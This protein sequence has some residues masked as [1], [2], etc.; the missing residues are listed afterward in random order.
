VPTHPLDQLDSLKNQFSADNAVKLLALLK[1]VAGLKLEDIGS[2]TKLH[3]LLLFICAHPHNSAV[4]RQAEAL[5]KNFPNLIL[6]SE[7]DGNDLSSLEH[8]EN[9]GIAGMTVTDAFTFPIVSWLSERNSSRLTFYWDWFEDENRIGELWPMFMPLLEEDA[10]VEANIPFR[11]WLSQA[12]GKQGEVSWLIERF[13]QLDVSEQEKA[14]RYN[15]QKLYVQWRYGY[16]D[17][18][19]GLRGPVSKLFF[20]DGALISRR[21]VRLREEFSKPPLELKTLSVLEGQNAI[22]R[23]RAASTVRYRELYGFTNGDPKSVKQVNIGRGVVLDIISLPPGKRLP[24]RTYHAAMIYK[25]GV[26]IGYFEGL[27]LFERMESGFNLYYTFREGETAWLYA[28]LLRVMRQI[29]GVTTFSLDPYQIGF[30]NEEGIQSGAFWFY[31]KLGFRSTDQDI[32]KR[33]ESEEAKIATRD[34]YRTSKAML[35][36]LSTA[37]MILELEEN[38][39]GEWDSFQIRNMGFAIQRL[40]EK[41]F[42]G[43]AGR[44]R[45]TA[46]SNLSHDL[47]FQ[48]EVD[49][50][51]AFENMAVTLL[52]VP[53]IQTW[54]I[55]EQE[56]LRKIVV[57]K[58]SASE[59]T[60][61]RLL[62]KHGRLRKAL[63]Q[64][65]STQHLI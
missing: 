2:L 31:R 39:T 25:N 6:Q 43:N 36:R 20:H 62:Q 57:A 47:K 34:N 46:V 1:R 51:K 21:D 56:L 29:T 30:E 27:A 65:G 40:M 53:E 28:Q 35:R 48:S 12:R 7:Q 14:E 23:A 5:L 16:D 41:K 4:L 9:S 22:D 42:D 50:G 58:C 45:K 52:L 33:T 18:R 3:E 55:E 60:Y 37:S 17:S 26:P 32:Q 38:R 64:L 54:S 59:E 10:F 61:L 24:L 15:A 44:L 8:P 49:K 19:T 11:N 63:I 13:A